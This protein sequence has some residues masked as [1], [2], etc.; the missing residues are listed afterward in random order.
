VKCFCNLF[1][2]VFKEQL[3]KHVFCCNPKAV[4]LQKKMEHIKSYIKVAISTLK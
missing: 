1:V 2:F 4:K 3:I